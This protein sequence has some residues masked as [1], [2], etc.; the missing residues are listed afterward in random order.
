MH[1]LSEFHG[2]LRRHPEAIAELDD[3]TYG[4]YARGIFPAGIAWLMRY[5]QLLRALAADAERNRAATTVASV[6]AQEAG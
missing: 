6:P 4:R 3:R 2:A 1:S 5:P